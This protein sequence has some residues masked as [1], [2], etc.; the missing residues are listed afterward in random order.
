MP[1]QNLCLATGNHFLGTAFRGIS[2]VLRL[3]YHPVTPRMALTTL[4]KDNDKLFFLLYIA[5]SSCQMLYQTS[6]NPHIIQNT[7]G[8]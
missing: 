2:K 8:V 3:L 1:W 6:V 4:E 7:Y 5:I